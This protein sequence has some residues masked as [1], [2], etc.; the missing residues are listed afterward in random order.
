MIL[1]AIAKQYTDIPGPRL[2]KEGEYS[3]EDFRE[4]VLIPLVEQA[5]AEN[6]K[7]L[8]DLDG[9]SGYPT[10]FLEEAFGG[11]VRVL[12][13]KSLIE[14]FEIKSEEEPALIE[15]IREYIRREVEKL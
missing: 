11:L 5:K 1:Y 13:D 8:I 9:G 4:S 12:K 3:G 10:S 7:I 15:E 2:K 6:K 14:L